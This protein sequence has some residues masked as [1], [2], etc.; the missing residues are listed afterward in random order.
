[1]KVDNMYIE[2]NCKIMFIVTDQYTCLYGLMIVK[3]VF[4]AVDY[5]N[6]FFKELKIIK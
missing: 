6:N 2:C 3:R 4:S 5:T 1:M